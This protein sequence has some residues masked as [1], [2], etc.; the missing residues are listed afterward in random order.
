MSLPPAEQPTTSDALAVCQRMLGRDK[1][2]IGYNDLIH[3]TQNPLLRCVIKMYSGSSGLLCYSLAED[4]EDTMENFS[5]LNALE[6]ILYKLFPKEWQQ[7]H[8]RG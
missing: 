2:H 5:S 7:M 8:V 4:T 3:I 1:A 6:Q